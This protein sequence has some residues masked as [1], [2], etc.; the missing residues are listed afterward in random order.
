MTR[1]VRYDSKPKLYGTQEAARYLGVSRRNLTYLLANDKIV[2]PVARLACGPI[3]SRSQLDEQLWMWQDDRPAQWDTARIKQMTLAKRLAKLEERWDALVRAMA[4]DERTH[5]VKAVWEDER[6]RRKRRYQGRS[7]LATKHEGWRALAE[8]KLL[9]LVADLGD[10]D[11]V[12]GQIA[13]E[14]E[15]AADLRK[16]L[17]AVKKRRAKR[18]LVSEAI[19]AHGGSQ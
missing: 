2:E 19:E 17:H 14:L 10:V 6:A 18:T 5:H 12:F 7:A 11:P 15:E 13:A 9:R 1:R 4:E 3:W 8:A 16:A